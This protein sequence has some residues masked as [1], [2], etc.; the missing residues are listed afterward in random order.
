MSLRDGCLDGETLWGAGK[1]DLTPVLRSC[2]VFGRIQPWVPSERG[3]RSFWSPPHCPFCRLDPLILCGR[4]SGFSR[5]GIGQS[6]AVS[7]F[8]I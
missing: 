3:N 1:K 6:S 4:L 7:S 2:F 5:L 8:C